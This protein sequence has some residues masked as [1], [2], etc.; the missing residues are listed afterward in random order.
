M[1]LEFLVG[2]DM[3]THIT[4]GLTLEAG[5]DYLVQA[6]A[7]LQRA[8]DLGIVHRDVKPENLFITNDGVLKVMDFGIAKRQRAPGVTVAGMVV[9]TPEYMSPEQAHGYSTLTHNAA[10]DDA[11]DHAARAAVDAQPQH[12]AR[13]QCAHPRAAREGR[14]QACGQRR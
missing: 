8:H 1:T 13:A 7:G 11:L 14:E 4:R 6:C 5:I 9:G 12:H 10:V 3:H 2:E